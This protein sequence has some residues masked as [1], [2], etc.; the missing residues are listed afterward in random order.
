[1]STAITITQ[2]EAGTAQIRLIPEKEGKYIVTLTYTQDITG[3]FLNEFIRFLNN[4]TEASRFVLPIC[5][6]DGIIDLIGGGDKFF[7]LDERTGDV[8]S[9]EL[10][11]DDF[12]ETCCKAFSMYT[13]HWAKFDTLDAPSDTPYLSDYTVH[14]SF[15]TDSV[16]EIKQYYLRKE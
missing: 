9:F 3:L 1:M 11:A 4:R 8:R 15:I 14:A 6:E 10:P 5:Q 13:D 7:A 2:P 12:I 16:E